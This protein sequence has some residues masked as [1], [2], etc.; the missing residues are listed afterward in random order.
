MSGIIAVLI[1][2]YSTLYS[3]RLI[4]P[5]E[6]YNSKLTALFNSQLIETQVT[7]RT[8]TGWLADRATECLTLG[9]GSQKTQKATDVFLDQWNTPVGDY[10]PCKGL[11][12]GS[13]FVAKDYET[14]SYAR[15]WHGHAI[16]TQWILLAIGLPNLKN[17]IWAINI[18]LIFYL[19]LILSLTRKKNRFA[20][21]GVSL[22]GPYFLFSDQ[23]ELHNSI[24]HLYSSIALM[25]TCV[26]FLRNYEK[27]SISQ[28]RLGTILGSLYCFF[29]FGLSPQSIPIAIISWAGI[30]LIFNEVSLKIVIKKIL[31]FLSAWI[32]GYLSTF[33][34]KWVIV[35]LLTDFPIWENARAQ[36]I[37]RSSQ[38]SDALSDGVGVHLLFARDFPAFIQSWIA[39]LS[40]FMIHLL[41]PRYSSLVLIFLVAGFF[42][43][44]MIMLVVKF[45]KGWKINDPL[46]RNLLALNSASLF[47]LLI[48]YAGLAQHS[49]DHATYTFR[50]IPIWFGGIFA[51]LVLMSKRFNQIKS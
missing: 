49:Y 6:E 40:A 7:K 32:F 20:L 22:M 33:I 29:L 13:G 21:L 16:V 15:Y 28:V 41:D 51:S 12:M 50:S 5:N 42:T 38:A 46:T 27:D 23:A 37:H 30:F 26:L 44:V 24:T 2:F 11:A 3:T 9:V 34:T 14:A 10:N 47:F 35:G 39:N 4:F 43:L 31:L 1:I 18:I 45:I 8:P 36:L 48:W 25:L 17:L 19:G